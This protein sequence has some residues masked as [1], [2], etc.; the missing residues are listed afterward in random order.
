MAV[1]FYVALPFFRT[2]DGV[3]PGQAQEM[4]SERA[5]LLVEIHDK[6]KQGDF[7]EGRDVGEG[8]SRDHA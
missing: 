3:A 4:P 6:K 2:E 8:G 5:A 1:T 7:A